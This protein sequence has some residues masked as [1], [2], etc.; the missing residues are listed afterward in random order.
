MADLVA[1]LT[2]GYA[3]KIVA[4]AE[5]KFADAL[6]KF[7]LGQ[8]SEF[9]NTTYH[10]PIIYGMLG[11]E[12]QTMADAAGVFSICRKILGPG[13]SES[14][15]ASI[16]SPLD[17]GMVTIFAEELLQVLKYVEQPDF[18]VQG[19]E[20]SGDNIW[21]GAADD[22]VIR[23]RGVEFVDGRT[24]GFAVILGAA[25]DSKAAKKIA[26][27]FLERN[28]YVFM[29]GESRG[30]RF[31]EQLKS[32]GLTLGWG[33]RLVSFGPDTSSVVFAL[34]FATRAA[35]SFGGIAAGDFSRILKYNQ[36]RIP[37]FVV[38]LGEVNEEWAANA[39]AAAN[40]GFPTILDRGIPGL[41]DAYKSIV[42]T[43][44]PQDKIAGRALEVRGIKI[45][46]AKVPIPVSY[47]P[48]FEGERVRGEDIYLEAGGGRSQAV[49]LLRMKPSA[50]IE[51]GKVQVIGK[52]IPGL[53]PGV[54]AP[55]AILV[56]VSGRRME[57][58]FEP[59]LERQIHHLLNYAQGLMHIGQRDIVWI[60]LSRH[61]VEKG[62][63]LAHIGKILH[64]KF[65]QDFGAIVDK[66]QVKIYTEAELVD[67]LLED[68]KEIYSKRDERLEGLTDEQ[69]DT[70]YSCTLCQSFAPTH[71]C[72][73]TPERPGL[74]GAYNWLDCRASFEINPTGPNQPVVKGEVIDPVYGQ[75]KGV[76]EFVKKASRGA[77][78]SFDA[79]GI[80]RTPMTS[81]GCFECIACILPQCQGFMTV[82]REFGEMTPVGMKFSTLAGMVGGGNINPGFVGHSKFYITSRKFLSAEGGL[83]RL[84][85][86]PRKLKEEIRDRLKKRAVELGVPD[87]LEK[88][89]DETVAQ[90]EEQALEFLKKVKH[91]VLNLA[92]I[93]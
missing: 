1:E 21:L 74:C 44:V 7:G 39:V 14:P 6:K 59:I 13:K 37:A 52:D 47:G 35:M 87:L 71:T 76:N 15:L 92:P 62:F 93:F 8:K 30:R 79:Y 69:V 18:Y 73:I 67:G 9:P 57:E 4:A 17:A 12:V 70:F 82:D 41:P 68:A 45:S 48:A 43:D 91:P 64:A 77:T 33:T 61:A 11:L 89:A 27:E 85:W 55:L 88:I 25:L 90:T 50:E 28:L 10:L 5:Q 16:P 66:V 53:K 51:D 80:L 2:V 22:L 63:T 81:C 23:R 3:N 24:S 49:E 56:E 65:H 54:N 58:D 86:M 20:V 29:A 72:I 38:G 31:A 19:E 84:V 40:F 75:W 60:R 26:E 42:I 36:E 78:E 83:L 32:E 46:V 34:G